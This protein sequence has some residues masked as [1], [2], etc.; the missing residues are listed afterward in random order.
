MGRGVVGRN[1]E[2]EVELRIRQMVM[3]IATRRQM[4]MQ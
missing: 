2:W 1:W 4:K 3:E